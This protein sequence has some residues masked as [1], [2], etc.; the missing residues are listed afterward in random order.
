MSTPLLFK[1][2]PSAAY[3][4]GYPR[5]CKRD[6]HIRE[7][8]EAKAATETSRAKLVQEIDVENCVYKM[9][10]KI[11]NELIIA[12]S[13]D[14]SSWVTIEMPLTYCPSHKAGY[15]ARVDTAAF[16][17]I[18]AK[19][20]SLDFRYEIVRYRLAISVYTS[21]YQL[22][23]IQQQLKLFSEQLDDTSSTA[24]E[25]QEPP[26]SASEHALRALYI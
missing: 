18:C 24:D 15:Y 17:E 26:F 12:V 9:Y 14:K 22:G 5:E 1:I 6:Q 21:P 8:K 2:K 7:A 13:E 10:K 3:P 11:N 20:K 25:I 19:L 16:T 23:I 4:T